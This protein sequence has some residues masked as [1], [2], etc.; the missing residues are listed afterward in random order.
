MIIPVKI[1]KEHKEEMIKSVQAFFEEERSES[2]GELGA[3]QLIDFMIKELAPYLYNKGIEDARKVI[4]EKMNQVDD[5]LY[6]LEK[7][8]NRNR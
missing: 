1:P 8:I 3:D 6:A 2:I 7:P 4:L 5:E